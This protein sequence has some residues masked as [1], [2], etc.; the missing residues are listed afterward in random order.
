MLLNEDDP[1]G[2]WLRSQKPARAP[3]KVQETGP[4]KAFGRS[5]DLLEASLDAAAA[6]QGGGK[7]SA[8]LSGVGLW[9]GSA[10]IVLSP[11]LRQRAEALYTGLWHSSATGKH[12]VEAVLLDHIGLTAAAESVPFWRS[13]LLLGRVGDRF[14]PTRRHLVLAGLAHTVVRRRDPEALAALHDALT[15]PMGAV[16]G[17]AA[18]HLARASMDRKHRLDEETAQRLTNLA[19]QDSAFEPRFLA[20]RWLARAGRRLPPEPLDGTLVF[21]VGLRRHAG[22]SR[23][24]EL[25][26]TQGLYDLHLA[27]LNSV[28]WDSDHL[29]AFY[30]TGD[31]RN[32]RFTSPDDDGAEGDP[33]LGE[34]GFM[35]GHRF[36]YLFDFGDNHLFELRVQAGGKARAGVKLPRVVA[37]TGKAPKQHSGD[38]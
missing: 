14:G 17:L 21:K 28:G 31:S 27:I 26:P 36:Q 18:E 8:N 37:K 3:A 6:S 33:V 12:M 23:T 22:V 34:L 30:L 10:G 5:L 25:A 24:L 15:H 38:W 4:L 2:G 13:T 35:V 19:Q 7:R 29:Y 11:P 16:R 1:L 32:A 9:H 20:R